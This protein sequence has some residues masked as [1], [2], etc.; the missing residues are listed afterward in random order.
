MIQLDT[1][2]ATT[3]QAQK[4]TQ[5]A[6]AA[7]EQL[8]SSAQDAKDALAKKFIAAKRHALFANAPPEAIK[9]FLEDPTLIIPLGNNDFEIA[10][11]TAAGVQ[12]G[13]LERLQ[14][15]YSVY[16]VNQFTHLLAPIP[17]WLREKL[18]L[19]PPPFEAYLDGTTHRQR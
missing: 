1:I 18:D 17:E 14:G 10:V 5:D 15:A 8:I 4:Q 2:F 11:P 3:E 19:Q 13:W 6:L 12:L 16:R 9:A 7:L